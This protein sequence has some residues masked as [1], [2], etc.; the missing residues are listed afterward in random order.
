MC[1]S[2]KL[3]GT[4]GTCLTIPIGEDPD[5]ECLG[6]E[7][8]GDSGCAKPTGSACLDGGDCSLGF[9]V[10]GYCCETFCLGTCNACSTAKTGQANGMCAP[11]S[12]NTDPDNEC[13]G[14][15][16]CSGVNGCAPALPNGS[17][18]PSSLECDSGA[19]VDGVCCNG[20]CNA[21]CKACNLAGTVGT[22]T[23]IPSGQDP[24]NECAGAKFCNG[25]ANCN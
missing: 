10:D 16:M 2:C 25:N 4:V 13:A 21:T 6:T 19:C 12:A 20:I 9:C 3:P 17:A 1:N 23:N 15:L 18:C 5:D 7:V 8:C 14:M 24:D 22:C 11:I